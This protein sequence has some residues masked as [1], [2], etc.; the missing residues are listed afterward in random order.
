[1]AIHAALQAWRFD[2]PGR[3]S[4]LLRR[5]VRRMALEDDTGSRFA[6]QVIA[7]GEEILRG[8]LTS[9]L[10]DRLAAVRVLGREVPILLRDDQGTSWIGA[11]DLIFE[12]AAGD[13]VV[14]DYKTDRLEEEAPAAARRYH[15]QMSI[16]L[17]AVR[18]ALPER[19]VRG[20]ILFLRDG[21]AVLLD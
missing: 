16:Y 19:R 14:A 11:C 9:P 17:Q 5:G 1:V 6:D 2:D 4:E 3:L 10:P 7:L 21:R 20:E 12:D 18:R 8:F 15:P 13:V